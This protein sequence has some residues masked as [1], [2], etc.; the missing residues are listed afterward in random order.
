MKT[1]ANP[2]RTLKL[3]QNSERKAC[4]IVSEENQRELL[5]ENDETLEAHLHNK[6]KSLSLSY[7]HTE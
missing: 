7:A 1:Q 6:T 5:Q 4:L 2:Y 3:Q